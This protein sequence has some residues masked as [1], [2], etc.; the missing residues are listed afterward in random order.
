V[1]A[2]VRA[3]EGLWGLPLWG[4]LCGCLCFFWGGG[5]DCFGCTG[6]VAQTALSLRLAEKKR[7]EYDSAWGRLVEWMSDRGVSELVPAVLNE[8]I[9]RVCAGHGSDY[10]ARVTRA[11][12]VWMCEL[13]G[14]ELCCDRVTWKLVEGLKRASRLGVSAFLSSSQ[15]L[16]IK[17]AGDSKVKWVVL[18]GMALALRPSEMVVSGLSCFNKA[19]GVFRTK[20]SKLRS[21]VG[22][23]SVP[24]WWVSV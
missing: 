1:R 23:S 16:L 8:Y 19:L 17:N 18:L 4:C 3:W 10:L 5:A 12:A 9:S 13:G 15:V 20:W 6:V 2:C 24:R 11:S 21:W 22:M 7:R 14:C